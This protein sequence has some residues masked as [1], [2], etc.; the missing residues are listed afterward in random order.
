MSAYETTISMLSNLPETDLLKVQDFIRT[1]FTSDTEAA[2]PYM[3]LKRDDIV[4]RLE[5]ARNHVDEGYVNDAHHASD[6]VR[7]RYGL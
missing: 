5:E 2:G 1:F 7:A 6:N 4:H 3:P